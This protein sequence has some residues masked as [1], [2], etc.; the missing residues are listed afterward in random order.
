MKFSFHFISMLY[1]SFHVLLLWKG[2][3]GERKTRRG[4]RTT[5][6][7]VLYIPAGVAR[8]DG[9]SAYTQ[10]HLASGHLLLYTVDV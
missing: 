1:I 2:G 7:F 5:A 4:R 9:G 3:G 6:K 10:V 8:G